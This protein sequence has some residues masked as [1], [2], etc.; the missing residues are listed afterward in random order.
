MPRPGRRRGRRRR[1]LPHLDR[2]PRQPLAHDVGLGGRRA[3]RP[4]RR[5]P[6]GGEHGLQRDPASPIRPPGRVVPDSRSRSNAT[7]WTDHSAAA[8]AAPAPRRTSRFCNRSNARRPAA[9]HTTSSPSRRSRPA[10]ARPLP[11]PPETTAH[12]GA[13]PRAQHHLARADGDESPKSVPLRLCAVEL[14]PVRAR[15]PGIEVRFVGRIRP[16]QEL[17]PACSRAV[18]ISLAAAGFPGS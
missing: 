18:R 12:V 7:K 14:S 2:R 15:R 9:F 10:A 8:R 1:R 16:P 17:L 13:A 3:Q 5:Q 11:Q 6:T 4:R